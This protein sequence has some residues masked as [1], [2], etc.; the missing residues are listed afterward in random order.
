MKKQSTQPRLFELDSLR[1][2]AALGIALWHYGNHF[3]AVPCFNVFIPFYLGGFYFVDFF[4]LLSGFIIAYVY[5]NNSKKFSF[6]NLFIIRLIRL[7]PLHFITLIIVIIQNAILVNILE[8]S[9][10]IYQFN[11]IKHFFSDSLDISDNYKG[12]LRKW[13]FGEEEC[14]DEYSGKWHNA[15]D[16]TEDNFNYFKKKAKAILSEQYLSIKISN[17]GMEILDIK[18]HVPPEYHM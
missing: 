7:Y 14:Y 12:Y 6:S 2:I 5:L 4:F 16:I 9:E 11:D 10:F 1:G 17:A 18:C 13:L 15:T 8:S 3:H